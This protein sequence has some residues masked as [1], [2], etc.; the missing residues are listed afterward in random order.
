MERSEC[1]D[2]LPSN[3]ILNSERSAAMTPCDENIIEPQNSMLAYEIS[4]INPQK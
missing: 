1:S 3:T 4:T 2:P